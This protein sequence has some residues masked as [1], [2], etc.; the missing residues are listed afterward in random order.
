MLVTPSRK[1]RATPVWRMSSCICPVGLLVLLLDPMYSPNSKRKQYVP[2]K[3]FREKRAGLICI[4]TSSSERRS[5]C[6]NPKIEYC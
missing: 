4:G 2:E 3:I 5:F 6:K 1:L